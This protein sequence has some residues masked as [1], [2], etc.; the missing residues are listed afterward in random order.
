[1]VVLIDAKE[2]FDK[3]QHPLI[4]KTLSKLEIG[5]K[6]LNTTK[7]IYSLEA[8]ATGFHGMMWW[9]KRRNEEVGDSV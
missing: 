9:L 8:F 6:F 3:I 4:I 5:G 7:D 1:M 2:I